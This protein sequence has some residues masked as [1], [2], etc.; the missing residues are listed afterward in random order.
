MKHETMSSDHASDRLGLETSTTTYDAPAFEHPETEEAGWSLHGATD[1]TSEGVSV[2]GFYPFDSLEQAVSLSWLQFTEGVDVMVATDAHPQAIDGV[3][4]PLQSLPLLCDPEG[5]VAEDYGADY[6]RVTAR[7][8]FLID[9]S[10]EVVRTWPA[11]PDPR[12]VHAAVLEQVGSP[13]SPAKRG[14]E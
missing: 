2:L 12:D 13:Q 3:A 1:R 14:A 8:V 4:P 6:G 7:R 5:E 11:N 10:H 9:S